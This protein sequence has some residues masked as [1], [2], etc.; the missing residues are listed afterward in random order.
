MIHLAMI[1]RSSPL[2]FGNSLSLFL[3]FSHWWR[4]VEQEEEVEEEQEEREEEEGEEEEGEGGRGGGGGGEMPMPSEDYWEAMSQSLIPQ[5]SEELKRGYQL[6]TE[7]CQ[8][9]SQCLARLQ[10]LHK[11]AHSMN[12][13]FRSKLNTLHATVLSLVSSVKK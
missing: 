2:E 10:E 1:K 7:A 12:I 5:L 9:E 3:F 11:K 8:A 13:T 6:W 4:K